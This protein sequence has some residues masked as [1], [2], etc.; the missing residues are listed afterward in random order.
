MYTFFIIINFFFNNTK[1]ILLYCQ[2]CLT[3]SVCMRNDTYYLPPILY[4]YRGVL[5]LRKKRTVPP[6]IIYY[7]RNM[8]SQEVCIGTFCAVCVGK[9]TFIFIFF[10]CLSCVHVRTR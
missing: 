1:Y 5:D 3:D 9:I 10:V 6:Y 8:S 7:S 2:S 4:E